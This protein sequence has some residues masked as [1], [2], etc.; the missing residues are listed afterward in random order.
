MRTCCLRPADNTHSARSPP[1]G[2]SA[3]I[4]ATP[5]SRR[6]PP[7]AR[8]LAARGRQSGFHGQLRQRH[9]RAAARRSDRVRRHVAPIRAA[10]GRRRSTLRGLERVLPVRQPRRLV[11]QHDL[12]LV[13]LHPLQ[14]AE[15]AHLIHRQLGKQR[16]EAF[17]VAIVHIAPELPE[18]VGRQAIGVQPHRTVGRLAH[19][20]AV[21]GSQQRHG[22]AVQ[23]Q[24]GATSPEIDPVDDVGPLVGAADLQGAAVAARKLDEVV[25]LQQDVAE[26][27]E[28][29]RVLQARADRVE[30]E[31]A[32][33]AEVAPDRRQE[34]E[35]AHPVE[36][37]GIVDHG[38]IRAEVAREG[39]VDA[40]D[41]GVDRGGV[42]HRARGVAKARVADAGSGAADQTILAGASRAGQG[43]TRTK[44]RRPEDRRR[45]S[46]PGWDYLTALNKASRR[47]FVPAMR[48][49]FG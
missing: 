17:D 16:Q 28:G 46:V 24:P 39:A 45:L 2:R 19:L 7:A 35:V 9:T 26:F 29:Q 4:V 48:S 6:P 44:K 34:I 32:V 33:D 41:I 37:L 38:D 27:E 21:A 18:A 47:S 13:Q 3:S 36:P 14:R 5:S 10:K 11:G 20:L 15:L 30:R 43:C 12:G 8:R 25:G 1:S 49:S 23:V 22:Q 40:G 31:H 42:Q